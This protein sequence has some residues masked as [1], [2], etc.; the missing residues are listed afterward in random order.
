MIII[1]KYTY[2]GL[3][4]SNFLQMVDGK[5]CRMCVILVG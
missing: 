5:I 4:L 2:L 1:M 3:L